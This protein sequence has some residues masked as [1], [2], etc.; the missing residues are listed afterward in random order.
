MPEPK[1]ELSPVKRALA[2]IRRP[3]GARVDELEKGAAD[4]IAIVGVGLRLP[5]GATDEESFWT[6][7]AEGLAMRFAIFADRWTGAPGMSR[8]GRMRAL[9]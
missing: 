8:T 9:V 7:L 6:L 1:S 4:P 3:A 2:E 5:G